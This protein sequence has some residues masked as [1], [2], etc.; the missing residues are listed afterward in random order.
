[1]SVVRIPHGT[2]V[3]LERLAECAAERALKAMGF[4]SCAWRHHGPVA[5]I[6]VPP[7]EFDR[8]I[9]LRE[10][11]RAPSAT[12]VSLRRVDLDGLRPAARTV[13][14]CACGRGGDVVSGPAA[15]SGSDEDKGRAPQELF[16]WLAWGVSSRCSAR[17]CSRPRCSTG[18][19]DARRSEDGG[20]LD[21]RRLRDAMVGARPLLVEQGL[22]AERTIESRVGAARLVFGLIGPGP[23]WPRLL[24]QRH[25]STRGIVRSRRG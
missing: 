4:H 18:V 15:V 9:E 22:L 5:R 8:A 17:T 25:V 6:E 16:V 14:D 21:S 3:T 12:P 23:T 10:R 20:A 19:P 2:P 7:T 24:R 13:R 1:V 11:S